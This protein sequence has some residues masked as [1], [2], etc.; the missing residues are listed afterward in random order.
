MDRDSLIKL[1]FRLG[2]SYQDMLTIIAL[3]GIIVSKRHLR[4]VL[5]ACA[6]YHWQYADLEDAIDFIVGQLEGP[7]KFHG[8]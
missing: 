2:M 7:G 5:R 3:Q 4:R 8:F 1:Y 6:L